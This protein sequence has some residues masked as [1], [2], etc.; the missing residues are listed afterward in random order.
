MH[1]E[2]SG[3][4][5][6]S[7]FIDPADSALVVV[8]MQNKWLKKEGCA[9]ADRGKGAVAGTVALLEK[10]RAA[11]SKIIFIQSVRKP[12]AL[13]FTAFGHELDITEGT[14]DAEIIDELRPTQGEAVV[15]KESYDPFNGTSLEEVLH[16]LDLVPCRSQIVV[17]GVATNV[18]F[19]CAATGF[20]VRGFVVYVPTDATA[21][22]SEKEEVIAFRHFIGPN[23]YNTVATRS[24]LVSMA[25][26]KVM[27]DPLIGSMLRS[28]VVFT[29][30]LY[31]AIT[32]LAASAD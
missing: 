20:R 15:V 1:V 6:R 8:D 13:E 29:D 18:A 26:D 12:D 24:D 10:F 2:I 5:V 31:K 7:V 19:D 25:A 28:D 27:E 9:L 22:V 17:T 21:A 14:W 30:P 3:P 32:S 11:G 23:Y 4:E 16:E